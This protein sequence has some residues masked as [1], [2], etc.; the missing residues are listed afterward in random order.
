MLLCLALS[1]LIAEGNYL[2]SAPWAFIS[3]VWIEPQSTQQS[4]ER[5][6]ELSE[7]E[8]EPDL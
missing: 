7:Y 2:M 5:S 1:F 3:L 8:Q 4:S 6:T